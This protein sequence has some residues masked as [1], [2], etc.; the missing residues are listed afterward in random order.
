M[1]VTTDLPV[2]ILLTFSKTGGARKFYSVFGVGNVQKSQYWQYFTGDWVSIASGSIRHEHITL[3]AS[4]ISLLE[5]FCRRFMLEML[6]A[7]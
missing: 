1:G 5:P 7:S 2:S 4:K 6:P 3:W